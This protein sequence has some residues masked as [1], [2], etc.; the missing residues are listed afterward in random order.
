MFVIMFC[1]K[2]TKRLVAHGQNDKSWDK[3]IESRGN[4]NDV[5]VVDKIL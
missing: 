4:Q 2:K 1:K 5:N 3:C